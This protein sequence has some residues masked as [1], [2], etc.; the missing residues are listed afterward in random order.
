MNKDNPAATQYHDDTYVRKIPAEPESGFSQQE[1]EV[2]HFKS[3][4]ATD[5]MKLDVGTKVENL[6][7]KLETVRKA[8]LLSYARWRSTWGPV[9]RA[10]TC[11]RTEGTSQRGAEVFRDEGNTS[12]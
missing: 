8:E 11:A 1:A 10:T 7:T 12:E 9:L 2:T 4:L 3:T 5:E 6:Q